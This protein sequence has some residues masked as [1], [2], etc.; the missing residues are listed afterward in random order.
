MAVSCM[1]NEKYAIYVIIGTVRALWTWLCFT[2]R[3]SSLR[4]KSIR[5]CCGCPGPRWASRA[6]RGVCEDDQTSA[7]S[8]TTIWRPARRVLRPTASSSLPSTSARRRRPGSRFPAAAIRRTTSQCTTTRDRAATTRETSAPRRRRREASPWASATRSTSFL[9]SLTSTE[10]ERS[11]T[12]LSATGASAYRYND[13]VKTSVRYRRG[14]QEQESP[15][16]FAL[17]SHNSV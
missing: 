1:H 5:D 2:E 3:I 6:H 17:C 11:W 7:A 16:L 10:S 15:S 12:R 14:H 9:S 8:T 4:S 13:A